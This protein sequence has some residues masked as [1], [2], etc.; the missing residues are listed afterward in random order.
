LQPR[1]VE[2]TS[3][4]I[5]KSGGSG[6]KQRNQ[7]IVG[8]AFGIKPMLDRP[9]AG[10]KGA[11]TDAVRAKSSCSNVSDVEACVRRD[12]KPVWKVTIEVTSQPPMMAFTIRARFCH[13]LSF[14]K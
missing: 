14:P 9:L 11:I 5:A 8:E 12:G 3:A 7:S 13:R 4:G 6:C 10:R 2:D 1:P